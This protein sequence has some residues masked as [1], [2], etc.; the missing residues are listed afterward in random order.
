MD[1]KGAEFE[2][3]SK[4]L[5]R[6]LNKLPKAFDEAIRVY[7]EQSA[8]KLENYAKEHR[9]WTDRTGQARQRLNASVSEDPK[10]YMI[11]LAHGVDY[12]IWLEL[13]HERRFAIISETID[14]VGSE[15][16]LPGFE[17]LLDRLKGL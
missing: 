6:N 5:E 7:A 14:K 4:E 16:I 11:T 2:M 17:H 10:G 8:L 1:D 3:D 12:G 13:A 15:T 9:R